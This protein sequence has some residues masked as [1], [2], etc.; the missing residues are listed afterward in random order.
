ML[1][2][3][4]ENILKTI[5]QLLPDKG[6]GVACLK[7][8]L[9][10]DLPNSLKYYFR[11]E[12]EALLR[13]EQLR[14]AK[15]S[16][17]NHNQ[18]EIKSLQQQIDSVLI[19][20][21]K[22][23]NMEHHMDDTIHLMINYLIRPQ[24]TLSNLIFEKNKTVSAQ[25]LIDIFRYFAPY[26]YLK[27]I[28]IKYFSE[29]KITAITEKEFKTLLWKADSEYIKRKSGYEL[30]ETISP[31]FELFNHYIRSTNYLL[32]IK[33]IIKYFEDKGLNLAIPRLEGEIAQGKTEI[34]KKELGEFLEDCRHALGSFQADIPNWDQQVNDDSA[35]QSIPKIK[36]EI[37]ESDKRK[38]IKKIFSHNEQAYL[39]LL[40]TLTKQSSWKQASK[41][42]DEIFIKYDV[43]PYSPEATKFVEIMS[44]QF[45]PKK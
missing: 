19:L 26:D 1:E 43:Y 17:F 7:D 25:N 42:I 37:S 16:R 30:A 18:P 3:E 23:Q 34:S 28:V 14:F 2:R 24:W 15:E 31:V 11:A 36:F 9:A 35:V 12:V 45:H 13:N 22:F 33:A 40:D 29:K 44:E 39:S 5:K 4:T 27:E 8:I 32:P 10:V 41:L 20:N 38:F 21:Y 6:T